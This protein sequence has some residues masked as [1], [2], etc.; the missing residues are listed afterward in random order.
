MPCFKSLDEIHSSYLLNIWVYIWL[1]RNVPGLLTK[2]RFFKSLFGINIILSWLEE[3][4]S[5]Y[6]LF[7]L[8]VYTYLE[9]IDHPERPTVT[10]ISVHFMSTGNRLRLLILWS[11]VRTRPQPEVSYPPVPVTQSSGPAR[12]PWYVVVLVLS[13]EG[14]YTFYSW[15]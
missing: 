5:I 6:R 14:G 9:Y 3:V 8:L 2:W 12:G 1:H 10:C 7:L 15:L 11:C 4:D 13:Q